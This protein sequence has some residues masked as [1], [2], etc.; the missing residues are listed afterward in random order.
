MPKYITVQDEDGINYEL[1]ATQLLQ[2]LQDEVAEFEQVTRHVSKAGLARCIKAAGY[3][4]SHSYRPDSDYE[5][6][7]NIFI[8][9]ENGRL[10]VGC[11]TFDTATTKKISTW[12]RRSPAKKA[13]KAVKRGSK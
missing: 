11:R 6:D 1:R 13:K 2:P 5:L 7:C 12:A 8:G 4:E 3:A 10:F 9:L